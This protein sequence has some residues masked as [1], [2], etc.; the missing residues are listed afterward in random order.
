LSFRPAPCD[1]ATMRLAAS[2]PVPPD[3]V[4]CR[5]VAR[6][7]EELGYD[8]VWIADTGAGPRCGTLQRYGP[9][10]REPADLVNPPHRLVVGDE[11]PP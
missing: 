7:V 5:R 4:M 6:R 9:R 2:L 10:L 3:L 1:E 8:S 11:R